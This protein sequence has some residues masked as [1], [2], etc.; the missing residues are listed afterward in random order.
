MEKVILFVNTFT[1]KTLNLTF[2]LI[3]I[4]YIK[5]CNV[6]NSI[7]TVH[8]PANLVR[9]YIFMQIDNY[10]YVSKIPY[11]CLHD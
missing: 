11:G 3:P 2:S 6:T 8:K 10:Q 1:L 9:P 4:E 7:L 5:E